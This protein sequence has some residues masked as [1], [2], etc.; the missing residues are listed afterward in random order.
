VA[1]V[2]ETLDQPAETTDNAGRLVARET[3]L[4]ITTGETW[5]I[6]DWGRGKRAAK[7]QLDCLGARQD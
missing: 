5:A 2:H 7:R 1:I 4:T 3:R 6:P